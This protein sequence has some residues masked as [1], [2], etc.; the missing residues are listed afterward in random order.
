MREKRKKKVG[1][2]LLR[3]GASCLGAHANMAHEGPHICWIA[4]EEAG[5]GGQFVVLL[6]KL[7]C[8]RWAEQHED[9]LTPIHYACRGPSRGAGAEQAGDL[10]AFARVG[11][12][13]RPRAR[14]LRGGSPAC[15]RFCAERMRTCGRATS[16]APQKHQN[17]A[18]R[19]CAC[20]GD[21]W[22][23]AEHGERRPLRHARTPALA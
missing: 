17:G 20:A 7:P 14:P 1:A 5:R 6:V 18:Q 16:T 9:G 19:V 22:G 21:R 10:S 12:D 8:E 3:R 15:W 13:S 11:G 2:A 23:T 4:F